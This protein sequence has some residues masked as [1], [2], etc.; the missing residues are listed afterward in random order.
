MDKAT[1]LVSLIS[2]RPSNLILI[3]TIRLSVFDSFSVFLLLLVLTILQFLGQ[4]MGVLV[5]HVG[6][7]VQLTVSVPHVGP[8]LLNRVTPCR[9]GFRLVEVGL[10]E[11][12]I[13]FE[14]VGSPS[15]VP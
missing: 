14:S 3:N 15:S 7:I 1:R 2:V 10:S 4:D 9:L 12:S 13:W 8:S 6:R 11:N 5:G